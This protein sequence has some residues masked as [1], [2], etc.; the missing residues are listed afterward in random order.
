[1]VDHHEEPQIVCDPQIL[2]GKPIIK[3][4]RI[5]VELIKGLARSGNSVD[6]ILRSYPHLSEKQ[7][8]KA[9]SYIENLG[10]K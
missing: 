4:T 6:R 3:G 8:L 9:L 2:G 1:M 10:G 7:V 5:S